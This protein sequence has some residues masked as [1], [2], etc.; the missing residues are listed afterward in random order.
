MKNRV[1]QSLSK[2][3]PCW[4]ES[5]AFWIESWR[6]STRIAMRW[7]ARIECKE[8]PQIHSR[9]WNSLKRRSGETCPGV[10]F[11]RGWHALSGGVWTM[12][13]LFYILRLCLLGPCWSGRDCLSSRLADSWK[14]N[15][16]LGRVLFRCKPANTESGVHTS[17]T[18]FTGLTLRTTIHPFSLR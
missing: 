17:T 13:L 1:T 12:S 8:A 15:N 6:N 16:L 7:G 14:V 4:E 5:Q 9:E 3:A 11:T 18:S 2:K 10:T